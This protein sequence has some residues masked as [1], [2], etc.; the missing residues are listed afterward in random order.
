MFEFKKRKFIK[1]FY[2]Y[3]QTTCKIKQLIVYRYDESKDTFY[4]TTQPLNPHQSL[5]ANLKK[6]LEK[7]A[8]NIQYSKF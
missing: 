3:F 2:Y 5:K 1:I 4:D 7:A 6:I 8:D